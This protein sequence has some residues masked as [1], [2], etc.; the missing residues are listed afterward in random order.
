MG[1]LVYAPVGVMISAIAALTA[2]TATIKSNRHTFMQ[3]NSLAF[4]QALLSD[5]DYKKALKLVAKAMDNRFDKPLAFF[6]NSDNNFTDDDLQTIWAIR[7]ILNVWERAAIAC[8]Y[9]LYDE[10]YLYKTYKSMVLDLGIQFRNFIHETQED[11][12][13]PDIY[14]YFSTLVLIWTIRRGSFS[15]KQ[16]KNELKLIYK[17]L[18]TIEAGKLPKKR[19]RLKKFR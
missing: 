11:R 19:H 15:S 14:K 8:V 17:Q 3:T 1:A 18:R 2:A 6:A 5:E 10:A 13:N 7:Y 12:D 4:Q 9:G 16:T